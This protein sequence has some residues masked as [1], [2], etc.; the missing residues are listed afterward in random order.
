MIFG[1]QSVGFA[2]VAKGEAI[3]C[4]ETIPPAASNCG[5]MMLCP[6]GVTSPEPKPMRQC[7][8][9]VQSV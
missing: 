6:S 3:S 2:A 9:K 8:D 7:P 1:L 5:T 4:G